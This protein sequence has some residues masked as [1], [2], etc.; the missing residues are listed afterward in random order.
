MEQVWNVM[1]RHLYFAA[2]AFELRILAFVLM[3]N[4]FHLLVMALKQ[5]LSEAMGFFLRET[6]RELTYSSSRI[7]QTYGG[8]FFRSSIRTH[9]Y[10][11]NCYKYVYR[12]PVQAGISTDVQAY[13]WSTLPGLLGES[14]LQIPVFEDTT[15]FS[16]IPGTLQWLNARPKDEHWMTIEKALRRRVF[17][18]PK[19]P[20]TKKAHALEV[21]L[22]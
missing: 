15:L 5:N 9:H 2:H 22:L 11:L 19:D 10:F 17:T 8:R 12:N 3:S 18:L 1:E 14:H 21:D 16:D 7:N 13:R 20:N 6:S 4:H